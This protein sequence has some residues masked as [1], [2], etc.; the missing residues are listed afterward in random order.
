MG[1]WQKIKEFFVGPLPEQI[2]NAVDGTAT[3]TLEELFAKLEGLAKGSE[4][5]LMAL[6]IVVS[7]VAE[8]LSKCAM[9]V[10]ESGEESSSGAIAYALNVSPNPNQ[11]ASEFWCAV[12]TKLLK[13]GRA[14]VVSERKRLWLADSFAVEQNGMAANVFSAVTINGQSTARKWAADD[15]IYFQLEPDSLSASVSRFYKIYAEA[16]EAAT[17]AF[18]QANAKRY[19][20]TIDAADAG[21]TEFSEKFKE[22]IS[23]QIQAFLSANTAVYPEFRGYKLT[24]MGIGDSGGAPSQKSVA[25]VL[26]LREEVFKIMAL[27]FKIPMAMMTGALTSQREIV[28]TFL[29]FGIDPYAELI[30]KELTRKCFSPA[31][32][33]RGC[34]IELD[35]QTIG[36][37]DIFDIA[38]DADKLVASGAMSINE[39]RERLGMPGKEGEFFEKHWITK[40]YSPESLALTPEALD[41]RSGTVISEDSVEIND[42]EDQ[43]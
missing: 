18:K 37:I 6:D 42:Y 15:A 8:A 39:V 43:V 11:N 2:E 12:V 5:R 33:R 27:A 7:Y 31:E 24:E 16:F 38:G 20:L 36:H 23:Q 26:D 1:A 32:W 17:S 34:R 10:Y 30:S 14:L 3:Y 13:E 9:R 4:L 40:N 21:D 29:T 35:T 19:K 22:E 28:Q 41:T 25:D